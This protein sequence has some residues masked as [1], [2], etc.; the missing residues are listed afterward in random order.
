VIDRIGY[1]GDLRAYQFDNFKT[2]ALG[3]GVA[4]VDGLQCCLEKIK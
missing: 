4:A 2:I 1:L 3:S